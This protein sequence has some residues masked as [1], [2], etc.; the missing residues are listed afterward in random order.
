MKSAY[1]MGCVWRVLSKNTGSTKTLYNS[2]QKYLAKSK[3]SS[4]IRQEQKNLRSATAI[5]KVNFWKKN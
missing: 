3:S 2:A 4:K 5:T 1:K